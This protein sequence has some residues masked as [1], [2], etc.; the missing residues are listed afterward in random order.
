MN[1][2][3][4]DIAGRMIP[5]ECGKILVAISGGADSVALL[6]ALLEAG[7]EVEAAHCNFHLRGEES[8]R[9]QHFVEDLCR[10]LGVK[11]HVEHFDVE[12]YRQS[13]R[14]PTSA[15]MACRDLRYEWFERLRT[16]SG[17]TH[18]AVAHNADDNAET[19]LLNL[20]RGSGIAGL[21]GMASVSATHIF[22]PLLQCRRKEIE[23]YL[24]Q[25]GQPYITDSTNRENVYRRNRIRNVVI[26]AIAAEFP[27]AAKGIATTIEHLQQAE[28]LL[29]RCI[30]EKRR[31]YFGTD[32]SIDIQSLAQN[33]PDA[34]FLLFHW[35]RP[36]GVSASQAHD[37][38]SQPELTG[39][40]FRTSD[41][42]EWY[43]KNGKL[44][45][46]AIPAE[47]SYGNISEMLEIELLPIG[48]FQPS[49][50]P[51]MAWFDPS[52]LDG[53]P[54][55]VR[56]WQKADRIKPFGMQ[57]SK[58]VS[59]IFNDA[60]IYGSDRLKYPILT[61]DDEILWIAGLRT[62]RLYQVDAAS[63]SFV[64]MTLRKSR[65]C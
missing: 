45:R 11:L 19:F 15:E 23:A 32:D 50:N 53:S 49:R 57:G 62:S 38:L 25:I 51:D 64:K 63:G 4:P 10:R 48:R 14:R 5:I 65:D 18:I 3:I 35:L 26:P 41:G 22:R 21:T 7:R 39:R 56:T 13:R 46:Q 36:E 8:N 16:E 59:D 6:R 30:D 37:I 24:E 20:F 28:S 55:S 60:K 54:L 52:V 29:G 1:R 27:D 9:D 31:I 61:K 34:E 12:A 33:E 58:L 47:T 44:H 43:S 17:C 40:R 42:H 2:S